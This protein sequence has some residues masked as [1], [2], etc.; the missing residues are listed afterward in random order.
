[1]KIAIALHGEATRSTLADEFY[2]VRF[3]VEANPNLPLIRELKKAGVEV[4]VCGQALNARGFAESAVAE[5]ISIAAAALTAVMNKQA[6]GYS[7]IPVH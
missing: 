4:F 6:D 3:G 5:E 2:K 1:V 7:Y